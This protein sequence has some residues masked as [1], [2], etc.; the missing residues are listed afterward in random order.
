M[1]SIL[2]NIFL[3]SFFTFFSFSQ[4]DNDGV[5]LE[6]EGKGCSY[7]KVKLLNSERYVCISDK[8][9]VN[10]GDYDKISKIEIDSVSNMRK[11][12]ITLSEEGSEKL[13]E[14]SKI[15]VGKNLA[16]VVDDEVICLMKVPGVISNGKIIVTEDPGYSSLQQTYRSVKSRI[17]LKDKVK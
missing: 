9:V 5:Y 14:I 16:F 3:L 7:K 6:F 13:L 11:F 15:Y 2:L 17:E 10:T 4:S 8:P 1:K 12:E